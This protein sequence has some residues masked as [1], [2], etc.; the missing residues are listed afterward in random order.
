MSEDKKTILD[1]IAKERNIE[2]SEIKPTPVDK[3]EVAKKIAIVAIILVIY[4]G[5]M[6]GLLL[7][8][9]L[10]FLIGVVAFIFA[11]S[12]L[13]K[14]LRIIFHVKDKNSDTAAN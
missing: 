14:L 9:N 6:T 4:A 12:P 13:I 11:V 5:L 1:E 7:T 10:L 2:V 3:K 8:K